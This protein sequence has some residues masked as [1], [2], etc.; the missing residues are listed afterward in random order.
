MES[1]RDNTPNFVQHINQ[2]RFQVGLYDFHTI[3]KMSPPQRQ[4]QSKSSVR[5]YYI[6]AI[7]SYIAKYSAAQLRAYRNVRICT[8]EYVLKTAI[9]L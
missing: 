4:I 8:N 2:V 1:L 6:R 7:F 3:Y 5:V 9:T